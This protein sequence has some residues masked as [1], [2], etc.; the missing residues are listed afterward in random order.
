MI[1]NEKCYISEGFIEGL[2]MKSANFN[3]NNVINMI[4]GLVENAKTEIIDH[5]QTFCMTKINDVLETNNNRL[6]DLFPSIWTVLK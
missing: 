4:I 3:Q 6:A 5:Q 1:I 2:I